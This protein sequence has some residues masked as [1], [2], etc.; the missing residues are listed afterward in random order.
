MTASHLMLKTC[1]VEC[2]AGHR[3]SRPRLDLR[4]ERDRA[5]STPLGSSRW[6]DERRDAAVD[7]VERWVLESAISGTD[8]SVLGKEDVSARRE[9]FH[10]FWMHLPHR[11]I[12]SLVWA[13]VCM[14]GV[15]YRRWK[16]VI[17]PRGGSASPLIDL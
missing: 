15:F 14:E 9:G 5:T 8:C 2:P 7:L 16:V 3:L 17:L 13:S 12:V 4:R 11:F 1:D 10:N 6:S